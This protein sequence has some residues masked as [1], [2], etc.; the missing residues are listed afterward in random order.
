MPAVFPD[1]IALE[2]ALRQLSNDGEAIR[3]E[4]LAKDRLQF[5]WK[6]LCE[7]YDSQGLRDVLRRH[8][9]MATSLP[10]QYE[11]LAK[12]IATRFLMQRIDLVEEVPCEPA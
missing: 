3:V 10:Q 2:K 1:L 11:V 12:H 4:R 5:R 7:Q 9:E 6:D 8:E